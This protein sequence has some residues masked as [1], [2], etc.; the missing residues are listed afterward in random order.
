MTSGL[1]A[2]A[3]LETEFVVVL[4]AIDVVEVEGA[5][6]PAPRVLVLGSFA[7]EP[8][9]ACLILSLIMSKLGL[10][11]LFSLS[12]LS[13]HPGALSSPVALTRPFPS[14]PLPLLPLGAEGDLLQGPPHFEGAGRRDGAAGILT[15]EVERLLE[16]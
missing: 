6:E 16:R 2:E 8:K 11:G 3:E 13:R 1:V 12:S 7:A 10:N 5:P 4:V 14:N 15:D 9:P